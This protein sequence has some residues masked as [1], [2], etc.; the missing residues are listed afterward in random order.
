M[1]GVPAPAFLTTVGR[2]TN[3]V[4]VTF[5]LMTRVLAMR[6]TLMTMVLLMLLMMRPMIEMM[7]RTI[8]TMMTMMTMIRT[9]RVV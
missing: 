3:Q 6:P 7:M 5:A 4:L 8:M 9:R 2:K 1:G